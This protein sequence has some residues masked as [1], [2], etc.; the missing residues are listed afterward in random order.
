MIDV[1]RNP[2]S[3][4]WERT[5]SDRICLMRGDHPHWWKLN[6]HD[7]FSPEHA[8]ATER[9]TLVALGLP[10]SLDEAKAQLAAAEQRA[11][12]Y[13]AFVADKG[14]FNDGCDKW[15]CVCFD[16]CQGCDQYGRPSGTLKKKADGGKEYV[17]LPHDPDCIV[18]EA[19]S[20]A[21]VVDEQVAKKERLFKIMGEWFVNAVNAGYKLPQAGEG[22]FS[23][24]EPRAIAD[25][26]KNIAAAEV[27]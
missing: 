14:V 20:S 18:L 12:R 9:A 10:E 16:R 23:T 21:P 25:Q 15:G 1:R 7:A 8:D 6:P 11:E 5:C 24:R 13:R 22:L 3:G 27:E 4:E 26:Y 2:D 17:L 19:S